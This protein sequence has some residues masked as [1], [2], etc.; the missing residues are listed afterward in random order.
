MT[1]PKPKIEKICKRCGA[2]YFTALAKSIY[3]SH[4]CYYAYSVLKEKSKKN[5]V[6]C[7]KEFY[8]AS[9]RQICCSDECSTTRKYILAKRRREPF[10]AGKIVECDYCKSPF[11]HK[12]VYHLF[13]SVNCRYESGL[14]RD[15]DKRKKIVT[16]CICNLT[17]V[18]GNTSK[19]CGSKECRRTYNLK[20]NYELLHNNWPRYLNSLCRKR[21]DPRIQKHFDGLFLME[22]LKKQDYK[23]AISGELLTCIAEMNTDKSKIRRVQQTNASIDRIKA[24]EPY[25]KENV[26][27]VC[28][29][30]NVARSNLE[31]NDYVDWCKKVADYQK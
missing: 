27:L 26:Q 24:G 4:D 25:T 15:R 20:K 21:K 17:V 3:C 1:K 28:L 19:T 6:I 8:S 18:T 22:L 13:C 11:F 31:I 14:K 29:S 2:A 5:C 7:E 23:C 30:V 10:L 9:A 16:C 12:G